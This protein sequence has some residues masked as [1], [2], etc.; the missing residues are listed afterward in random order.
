VNICGQAAG[1]IPK[2]A[3]RSTRGTRLD[4]DRRRGRRHAN[5]TQAHG[6]TS[7]WV[8]PVK[9]LSTKGLASRFDSCPI[10]LHKR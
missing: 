2:P 5:V 7:R 3:S 1:R 10:H 6:L 8:L 9:G 4:M